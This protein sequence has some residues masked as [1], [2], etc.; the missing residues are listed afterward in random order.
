MTNDG[1]KLIHIIGNHRINSIEQTLIEVYIEGTLSF[2]Y[3]V[4]D[5]WEELPLVDPSLR[6]S[7]S[8]GVLCY[9]DILSVSDRILSLKLDDER[10]VWAYLETERF[11]VREFSG[12]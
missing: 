12:N 5:F 1:G 11:L 10:Y 4:G 6:T 7:A 9:L 2:E 8:P 3:K